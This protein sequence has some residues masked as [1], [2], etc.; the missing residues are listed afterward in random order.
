MKEVTKPMEMDSEFQ[1]L[2]REDENVRQ[3]YT[4]LILEITSR[5]TQSS[6]V[7]RELCRFYK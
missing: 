5:C 1:S 2:G 6:I 7:D 3:P 4:V